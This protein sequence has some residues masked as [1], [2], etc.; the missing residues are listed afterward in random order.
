MSMQNRSISFNLADPAQKELYDYTK[1][2]A[3]FSGYIKSLIE[4][5]RTIRKLD[6]PKKPEKVT[7]IVNKPNSGGLTFKIHS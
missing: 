2:V 4:K 6:T 3:N 5:D 1:K 7:T